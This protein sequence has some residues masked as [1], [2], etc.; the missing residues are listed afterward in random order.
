[1]ILQPKD[2]PKPVTA[3]NLDKPL[4]LIGQEESTKAGPLSLQSGRQPAATG[5]W[6]A[7]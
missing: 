5:R 3:C 4:P 7:V 1:M 6:L 2:T